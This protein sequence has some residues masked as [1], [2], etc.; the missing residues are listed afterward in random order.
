MEIKYENL[1][2]ID[3]L[4]NK[5][6]DIEQKISS[7]KRWLNI[8]EVAYYLGYSKDH[9]YKLKT[10]TFIQGIHYHK[11]IGRILFDKIEIDRWVTTSA[12]KINTN[13]IA[14]KILEGIL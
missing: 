12:S 8:A 4:I 13:D 1:E 11:K 9:I 6:E 5:L 3:I 2:K 10:D 14:N 7:E